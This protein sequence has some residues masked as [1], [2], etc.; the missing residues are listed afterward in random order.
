MIQLQPGGS[1]SSK[2]V[3][4]CK[5]DVPSTTLFTLD[6]ST[7]NDSENNF[8]AKIGSAL[9][10]IFRWCVRTKTNLFR[11]PH[12]QQRLLTWQLI[13]GLSTATVQHLAVCNY[14]IKNSTSLPLQFHGGRAAL[15][16]N[17]SNNAA[18][19]TAAAS[20]RGDG[21]AANRSIFCPP[22]IPHRNPRKLRLTKDMFILAHLGYMTS[23]PNRRHWEL[24][25][26]C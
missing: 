7:N 26:Y 19:Y 13:P 6:G 5:Y 4:V 15:C 9:L 18:F 20:R 1:R 25:G 8:P 21:A 3:P 24:A 23:G 17:L 12:R 14:S 10:R 11:N 2:Y 16:P 22:R